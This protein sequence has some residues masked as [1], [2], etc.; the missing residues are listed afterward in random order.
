MEDLEFQAEGGTGPPPSSEADPE[1]WA[2]AV[3]DAQFAL[4]RPL[5]APVQHTTLRLTQDDWEDTK[6]E[7]EGWVQCGP[8]SCA[9]RLLRLLLV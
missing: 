2:P 6:R 8:L 1:A 3:F 4:L 7:R 5:L 9:A